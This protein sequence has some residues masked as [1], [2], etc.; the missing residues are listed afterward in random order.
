M[1]PTKWQGYVTVQHFGHLCT[2]TRAL[3][4]GCDVTAADLENSG[5]VLHVVSLNK[6]AR[7]TINKKRLTGLGKR[8]TDNKGVGHNNRDLN[9]Y[10]SYHKPGE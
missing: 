7:N 6:T 8:H 3:Q 4:T 10:D 5:S 2:C 9:A 1:V